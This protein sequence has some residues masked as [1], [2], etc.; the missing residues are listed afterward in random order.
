MRG[1]IA[2]RLDGSLALAMAPA[3]LA[4]GSAHAEV[5]AS[6]PAGFAIE[7]VVTVAAPAAAVWDTVRAIQTWWDAEHSYSGDAANLYLDAQATG[8]FCEKLPGKGS[9]EH[10][11]VVYVAPGQMIRL[12]GGL[13]PLQAEAVAGTLSITLKP[14]GGAQTQ[15]TLSYIVGGYMRQGGEAMAPLV[16]TVLGQQLERL[17]A[18]AEKPVEAS[19]PSTKPRGGS[20]D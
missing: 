14:V 18:T 9:I 1:I 3:L 6:T 20:G 11:H 16:D 15:V 8:C 2:R 5:K 17:K 12:T 7:Q 4:A 13:G 19:P 10:M